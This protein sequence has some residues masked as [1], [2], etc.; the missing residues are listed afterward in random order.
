MNPL[1]SR[2]TQLKLRHMPSEDVELRQRA[3]LAQLI[4]GILSLVAFVRYLAAIWGAAVTPEAFTLGVRIAFPIIQ[5]ASVLL[6]ALVCFYFLHKGRIRLAAHLFFAGFNTFT[7]I[8]FLT[9]AQPS[10]FPYLFLISIVAIAFIDSVKASMAHTGLTL[11]AVL[12]GAAVLGSAAFDVRYMATLVTLVSII[13]LS[14]WVT[15]VNLQDK[16]RIL[17]RRA[18]QLELSAKISQ[19]AAEKLESGAI[20]KEVV[21]RIRAEFGHY[22]VSVFLLDPS[23]SQLVLEE[24]TGQ[25]GQQLKAKKFRLDLKDRAIVSWVGANQQARVAGDVRQDSD[26]H[27]EAVLSQTK[28]EMAFPLIARGQLLGVLDVQS[29]EVDAFKTEDTAVMQIVANQVAINIDN[30]RLLSQTESR[31]RQLSAIHRFTQALS[32]AP[33]LR[34]VF[35]DVRREVFALVKATGMS[36]SLLTP[37]KNFLDWI[38][39]YEYGAEVDLS[40]TPPLPSDQGFSSRVVVTQEMF[41]IEQDIKTLQRELQSTT[42]GAMPEVWLGL[43]LIVANELIG[44]LAI[45]NKEPFAEGELDTLKTIAGPAAI[46]IKNLLQ[47]EEIQESLAAQ[48]RQRVLLQTASEVAAAA[49][50]ILDVDELLQRSVALIQERFSLYYVGLFLVDAAR[51]EAVLRAG[52][53]EAGRVQLAEGRRLA[54]GGRSLIG[55]ATGDGSAR[56]TQ[57]VRQDKEWLPNPYLPDT[58]SEL[59][60]PLRVRGRISGALTVQSVEPNAFSEEKIG[61]LQTMSDQLAVAIENVRLLQRAERRAHSQQLLNEISQQLYR[62]PD[63]DEIIGVG[64]RALSERLGGAPVGLRLHRES[65]APDNGSATGESDGG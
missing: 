3:H 17:Q 50:D 27:T 60:L 51:N 53:G 41:L 35:E 64:L 31:Y 22:H 16:T 8:E 49:A 54:V 9:D 23:S 63:V 15:A 52:T 59:A 32:L 2:L 11:A 44:V 48:M 10:P 46:A 20:L 21:E 7:F 5:A 26:Y 24:A 4:I 65:D 28:S 36:I 33:T 19:G 12:A 61:I 29:Q 40:A 6:F 38:Y 30:S 43:P 18:R 39:G 58:R 57:D 37:D 56:I 45:E 13:S 1:T 34:H 55:G 42:V 25:P 62:S 47:L 14:A